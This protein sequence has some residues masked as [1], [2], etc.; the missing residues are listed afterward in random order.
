MVRTRVE[1]AQLERRTGEL[2]GPTVISALLETEGIHGEHR[3]IAGNLACPERQ[4][5]LDPL[6]DAVEVAGHIVE[7]MR[8]LQ[9]KYVKR[10]RGQQGAEPRLGQFIIVVEDGGE[11]GEVHALALVGRQARRTCEHRTRRLYTAR[12]PSAHEQI[13]LQ[14]VRHEE[15]GSVL[16]GKRQRLVHAA[17][18]ALEHRERAFIGRQRRWI[19]ARYPVSARIGEAVIGGVLRW[20]GKHDRS[21]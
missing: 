5:R 16:E 14:Y 20:G 19:G 8:D 11:D 21:P 18:P 6:P 4:D 15:I 17:A 12:I 3:V 2:V 1:R 13:G 7:R 10:M 9:G